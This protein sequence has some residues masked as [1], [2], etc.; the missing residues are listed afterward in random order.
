MFF[1]WTQPSRTDDVTLAA[2][3]WL[4]IQYGNTKQLISTIMRSNSDHIIDQLVNNF[5]QIIVQLLASLKLLNRVGETR[6]CV[7]VNQI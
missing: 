7:I 6:L 4:L 5:V 1:K 2:I 3:R